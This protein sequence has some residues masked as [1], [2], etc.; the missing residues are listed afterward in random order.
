[1]VQRIFGGG[2]GIPSFGQDLLKSIPEVLGAE[3]RGRE[4]P[5]R[6]QNGAAVPIGHLSFGPGLTDAMDSRQ[7][8]VVGRRGSGA[9]RGPE[10]LQQGKET[11]VLGCPPES[12]GQTEV[13]GCGGKRDGGGTVFDQGGDL[14]G[15]A[16]I[17]LVDDTGLAVDAATLDDV[18]VE[19]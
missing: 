17:G 1:M 15:G 14:L 8:Q 18:V 5:G 13:A 4:S 10:G 2:K 3:A 6:I 7:Q 9:G 11:S 16:Q 19:L 12:A